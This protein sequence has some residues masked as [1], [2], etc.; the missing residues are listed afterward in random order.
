MLRIVSLFLLCV[1]SYRV[2]AIS[3]ISVKGTKLYDED[4]N[5]FFVKGIAYSRTNS[6]IVDVL[7]D[8]NQCQVDA[9]LMKNLG[10]NTIRVYIVDGLES[11]DGCM[12]AF[13]SQGIY[14]WLDLLTPMVAFN[15][16]HPE[17][18]MAMYNNW[19]A[20]IDAF[21]GYD[22]ILFFTVG[23]EV[24]ND[25]DSTKCAPY[26]KAAV[27]DIKAFRDARGYRPI[28]IAYSAADIINFRQSTAE[29]LACGDPSD[30]ID[31]FGMNMYSWCGNS[32][33]YSSGYDVLYE[34]YQAMN[35]PVLFSETGCK[36]ESDTRNFD[37]VSAMLGPV[38][39]AVFSGTV[40]YEW[41]YEANEYGIVNYTNGDNKG[42]PTTLPEYNSLRTV[43]ST[44]NPTGTTMKDYTPSNTAPVCPKS[45]HD[46]RVDANAALPTIAGLKTES[47]TARTT[48]SGTSTATQTG[49]AAAVDSG[50]PSGTSFSS[51]GNGQV[52]GG[53]SDSDNRSLATGVIAG[54]AV[55][56]IAAGA[57]A[58]FAAFFI[59]RKRKTAKRQ[60]QEAQTAIAN[61]QNGSGDETHIYKKEL[62]AD[63][64]GHYAP[65]QELPN[66]NMIH[67]LGH[68]ERRIYH[69]MD[70]NAPAEDNIH[71]RGE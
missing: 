55:G 6:A 56:G 48:I 15:R 24:I 46:W 34:E 14:V 4:G 57:A 13:E 25:I 27:R 66:D 32:S 11:H 5:Q 69:E 36:P 22:N 3:P 37:E 53:A 40:V 52:G 49:T 10:V 23:N 41:K 54:I 26:I 1:V 62:P 39:Q 44:A 68:D 61:Y 71:D 30:G 45:D 16:E 12:Q 65:K 8:T 33:I 51:A 67:E 21:A 59:F 43:L 35:I 20:T 2:D 7:A 9:G 28:P 50:Q 31:V 64:A 42:F 18:T 58:M 19:T 17:W 38:F 29:Y 47:V 63:S 70:G 60:Q